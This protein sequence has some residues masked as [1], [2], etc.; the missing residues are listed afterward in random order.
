MG[1][2]GLEITEERLRSKFVGCLLGVAVGDALGASFEG[3]PPIEAGW[4]EVEGTL[5]YTDDTQMT[6]GVAE[7][8]I[9]NGGFNGE[10]M[11]KTFIKNYDPTRGY[12]PG[13]P[14]VFRWIKAGIP[15]NKAAKRLYGGMGSYGN[16]AAMRIAPVGL[17]YYDEPDKL[18]EI[19]RQVSSITH[20]HPL[21]VEGAAIQAYAVALAVKTE[22]ESLDREAY[23]QKLLDLAES[24]V[25]RGKLEAV[26]EL[27]RVNAPRS[28]V[29]REL[30]NGVEAFNSV[31]TAIYTF[32][33]TETFKEAVLHAISL[34]GDTDTIA[35]MT[36][37]IAGAHHGEESI[38]KTWINALENGEK[39]R[40]YI[41]N[42]AEELWRMK[43]QKR[44]R[45]KKPY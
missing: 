1:V 34:G 19:A 15:W 16:G 25:Y 18:K 23:I 30:G 13:P 22:P 39:G 37:A 4:V 10:H 11:A 44:R 3:L 29:V 14:R 12:G 7:S 38:P 33:S 9:E 5:R 36:G 40:T 32:L 2:S 27:L 6:I 45:V 35:S 26:R 21:G 8:L 20:T 42:L 31:P 43:T 28:L 24:P 41:K 17:L